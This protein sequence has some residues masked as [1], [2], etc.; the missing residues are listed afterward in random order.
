[1]RKIMSFVLLLE[2]VYQ[3]EE[4]TI[5]SFESYLCYLKITRPYVALCSCPHF[6]SVVSCQIKT[7]PKNTNSHSCTTRMNNKPKVFHQVII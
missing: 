1:M 3:D 2:R 6:F 7:Q 4:I 5:V